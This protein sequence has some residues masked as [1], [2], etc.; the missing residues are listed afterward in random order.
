MRQWCLHRGNQLILDLQAATDNMFSKMPRT[1]IGVL[2]VN[3]VAPAVT[4]R[5]VCLSF[6]FINASS[7]SGEPVVIAA[8]IAH[9]RFQE[10]F[11]LFQSLYRYRCAFGWRPGK[12]NS[13]IDRKEF[14]SHI[15]LQSSKIGN[16][17]VQCNVVDETLWAECSRTYTGR[18]AV[19]PQ[20]EPLRSWLVKH[21]Q[22]SL[23]SH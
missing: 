15:F 14:T 3:D 8:V 5:L 23:P 7:E 4:S 12:P 1:S 11:V 20:N 19:D 9:S 18:G 17:V 21:L 6:P 22:S 13:T 10:K 16:V 2:C